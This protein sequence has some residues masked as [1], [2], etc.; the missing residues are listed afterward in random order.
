MPAALPPDAPALV[1][2]AGGT[3]TA[4]EA[5]APEAAA[6]IASIIRVENP[7]VD[8]RTAWA[9]DDDGTGGSPGRL[10]AVLAEAAATRPAA[11]PAAVVV[12]LLALPH[13]GVLA[14]IR[15]SVAASGIS[16]VI[17]TPANTSVPLAEVLHIRLAEAGLARA[18]RVRLFSIT[19]AADG[20]IVATAGGSEAVAAA[21]PA[22]VLLA[23]RLAL[24]VF[25]ASLD[26]RPSVHD[27][28]A[29]LRGMGARRLAIAPC[30]IGPEARPGDL[31]AACASAGADCA[32]PVGA[33][34]KI[35]RIIALAYGEALAGIEAGGPA[36]PAGPAGPFPGRGPRTSR[37]G[38]G[39][40]TGGQEAR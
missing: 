4:Q 28:A 9:G 16:A 1:L 30:F 18:D 3:G 40:D 15:A 11:G 17:A 12:P 5:G 29:K 6:E 7:A 13:P 22:A 26:G 10:P 25:A 35:A 32:P 23:A 34:D 27:A 19:T 14:S 20:V 8:V 2:T 33:H 38:G 21:S 24:P 36:A 31:E 37:P 39:E